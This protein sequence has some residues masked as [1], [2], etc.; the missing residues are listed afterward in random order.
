MVEM[1][2]HRKNSLTE[3][4]ENLKEVIDWFL[5]V[6]GKDSGGNGISKGTELQNAVEALKGFNKNIGGL[7]TINVA[8]IFGYVTDGLKE[9]I[10]YDG[11]WT[12]SGKGIGRKD[13]PS[14]T[15]S[16]TNDAQWK[17]DLNKPGTQDANKVALIFLGTM[18]IVYFCLSY[19][20]WRCSS[21]HGKGDWAQ[22]TVGGGG[23]VYLNHFLKAMGYSDNML[24]N[25]IS[26]QSV[27]DNVASELDEL[28][29]TARSSGDY[30]TFLDDLERQI[31][32]RKPI[33]CPLAGCFLLA[34]EYFTFKKADKVTQAIKTL[35]T[36]FKEFSQNAEITQSSALT[37][38]PYDNLKH[39]ITDLL[40]KVKK[41]T[42]QEPTTHV[43]VQNDGA[44]GQLA[45][46]SPSP[47]G[48]VAG[49]L[50]TLGLG[51][52]AAA[53]YVFNLG[54]AKTLKLLEDV[55]N[56]DTKLSVDIQKVV[57]ALADSSENG[58][59]GKLADGLQQFI[60]YENGNSNG[61]PKI[62]GGGILPANVA[63]Y[64]I[65][66]AVLNF[67][68]RFLEGLCGIEQLKGDTNKSKVLEVIGKLRKCVGTGTVPEG[69]DQLVEGIKRKVEEGFDSKINSRG[70]NGTL[71]TVF[72]ALKDLVNHNSRFSD[73][74]ENVNGFTGAVE[75]YIG[76]VSQKLESD[77]SNALSK[78]FNEL[79]TFFSQ[80]K[81]KPLT[82]KDNEHL[83]LKKEKLD[84]YVTS[85]TD[86]AN[87]PGLISDINKLKTDNKFKDHANAAV[88]TAVR[89]ASHAFLAELETKTYTSFYNGGNWKESISYY[90]GGESQVLKTKCAKI[91]LGCL[92]LYYQALTYIYW[93]CHEKGG[94]WR[95]LTLGGGALRSYFD[96]Q[97]LLPLY[98]DTNKRGAHIAENALKGFSELTKGMEGA[99]SSPSFP[100]ASFNEKLMGL[101][102]SGTNL[103]NTCPLSAL[104][105]G[106]SCYFRYQQI[107]TTKHAVGAPKTIREML[108]FL[109]AL[110]FSP[111][112]D[113]FDGY[114]T[115]YFKGI[116][117]DAQ[118]KN[119]DYELKLQVADSGQKSGG[120]T[121]SAADL[122]SHLLS[123]AIFIPGALG[124]I[125]GPGA[126]EKSEPW[127][128]SL[129]SNSQFNFNIP[130]SGAGIFSALSNYAYA[131]Q[132][133]LSF[134]YI[135][136]RD[137]YT[138]ACGWNQCTFGKDINKGSKA[139]V[140]SHICNG[141]DCSSVANCKHNGNGASTS[142][143]HNKID[144]PNSCGQGSNKSPLQAFLT[145][146]LSGFCRKLP[147]SASNHLAFC[148]G[149]LCHVPMGFNSKDLR[150]ESNANTQGENICLTLG[151]F[152]GGFNTP[153]RQLSEK[154]G[155]LTKRTPRSLGDLFGFV[156]HLNGQLFPN[157][158]LG[159]ITSAGWFGELKDE[160][161]FSYQLTSESGQKLK[162]FV[163]T[164]HNDTHPDLTSLYSLKCDQQNYNCGPYLYPLTQPT[165]ATYAPKFA[166]TYFSWVL[167][168]AD[169][170]QTGLQEMLSEFT[171]IDCKRS[172]CK[173][174]STSTCQCTPGQH[175][176]SGGKQCDCNSVVHCGGVLPLL[177][178][179]GFTFSSTGALFCEGTDGTNTK[180]NCANFHTRLQSVINGEPLR[181]LFESIDDF[182]YLFRYYFLSNLSGFWTIYIC[183]ILYTFFFL[184]D[185]LHLRS[186]L[187]LT[188]SH[189][190]PPLALFTSGTPL[191]VTKLTYIGQ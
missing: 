117:P 143:I 17:K 179:Y 146:C 39:L 31:S 64:Q 165:G 109:A 137:T 4:P 113:E 50:T 142:C 111:Q 61:T 96:S 72:S 178:R 89:D 91:F 160:L 47:A 9:F 76:E 53:A 59:I 32:Y 130:S 170:L 122:K 12:V 152:C 176:T 40:D 65:C 183:L 34:R 42:P 6:G 95:N 184:L 5:R 189:V 163:G 131:L 38:N 125:Q 104:F 1:T 188:S 127:L 63:K 29:A 56:S 121:L 141:Y 150:A 11:D 44:T 20:Y 136:C 173:T 128:H 124:V 85:L 147:G 75:K 187:K 126:T 115:E 171:Q 135:Q 101:V 106:A 182:L 119:D 81:T 190:V 27:M 129:F 67:A 74:K 7:G 100:Y 41:F 133:Q 172:G 35:K 185:T 186:H 58:L 57:Q 158:S 46:Q 162:T 156:W 180:R 134:L 166:L 86:A 108:Y 8:G 73:G 140:L 51:G 23:A 116:V 45:N 43:S 157:S 66:N 22:Q 97:G 71:N 145:D 87:N 144:D 13:P 168:L 80:L 62:T 25:A 123:T 191:P 120:N 181:D 28:K 55:E 155:C 98:V 54:G 118:N 3:W 78:L 60:G 21:S 161:P 26:G 68:I 70:G 93:G 151:S 112:Y 103:P 79:K 174:K 37:P 52:G 175:G 36:K 24:N 132:F 14:Y 15:S 114:V 149:Y 19:L 92:P 16:Y 94:G 102:N 154:L 69:F 177:Y 84:T 83:D 2:T 153:L 167:Y 139:P 88:F 77:G 82:L 30:S 148:A 49:T 105:Y 90:A 48:P 18:P 33:K 10:G 164:G 159:D 107:A 99:T 138:K 110:Q 169:E